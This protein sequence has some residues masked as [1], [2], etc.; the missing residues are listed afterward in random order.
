MKSLLS[1]IENFEEAT[2]YSSIE[3]KQNP[4]KDGSEVKLGCT[5]VE[6]ET[7]VNYCENWERVLPLQQ[8]K[9]WEKMKSKANMK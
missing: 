6:R 8:L 4:S 3:K 5:I 9:V 7:K 2:R 1:R